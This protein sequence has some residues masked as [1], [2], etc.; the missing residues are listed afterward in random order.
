[1]KIKFNFESQPGQII[2]RY[3]LCP[4]CSE[5][6]EGTKIGESCPECGDEIDDEGLMSEDIWDFFDTENI[7]DKVAGLFFEWSDEKM[8]DA[9]DNYGTLANTATITIKGE[10]SFEGHYPEDD[11]IITLHHFFPEKKIEKMTFEEFK[12]TGCMH[13]DIFPLIDEIEQRLSLLTNDWS[14]NWKTEELTEFDN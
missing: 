2:E 6:I 3:L 12:K 5:N 13:S 7:D 4:W 9:K 1:M 11:K 10:I 14:I 8:V